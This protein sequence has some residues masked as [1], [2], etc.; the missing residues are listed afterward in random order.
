MKTTINKIIESE[1]MYEE[2]LPAQIRRKNREIGIIEEE[3][4]GILYGWV[5]DKEQPELA[6]SVRLLVDEAVI[7]QAKCDIY[8]EDLLI[9]Q[10]CSG[11]NGFAIKIPDNVDLEN[12]KLQIYVESELEIDKSLGNIIKKN[13]TKIFYYPDYSRT[14]PYQSLLNCSVQDDLE[15]ISGSI[16]KA[17]DSLISNVDFNTNYIFHLHWL[18]PIINSAINEWDAL[19]KS[20]IFIA[21]LKCFI[22]VGGVIVWTIHNT[23]S[24]ESKW[25]N[26]EIF[27]CT[28]LTKLVKII[29]LHSKK[30]IETIE[31][32]YKLPKEKIRIIPHPNFIDAYPNT[33]NQ[34]EC[35]KRLSIPENSFVFGF[36]GQIRPYK[37][38]ENLIN[39]FR[40]LYKKNKNI[41]LLIAGKVSHPYQSNHFSDITKDLL[42]CITIVENYI[43]DDEL[44]LY[45]N[46]SDVIVF[47]YKEVLT[48]GSLMNALS[49]SKAVLA[50]SV[51]MISEVI[52]D[53]V[54]GFLYDKSNPNELPSSL[55]RC[56]NHPKNELIKLS[57]A[58]HETAEKFNW[59]LFSKDYCNA[60]YAA[61]K[62][63]KIDLNTRNS[64]SL[65]YS[66]K[67]NKSNKKVAII[68][69]MHGNINDVSRLIVSIE[70][71]TYKDIEIFLVD[72]NS[73]ENYDLQEMIALSTATSI[74][75]TC[76]KLIENHGYAY[77]NN[78]AINFA[79]KGEFE[80]IWIL[81]PDMQ[82]SNY[83]LEKFID[84]SMQYPQISIFGGA[85][86]YGD[87]KQ[88]I[89]SAGGKISLSPYL[90]VSHIFGG[91]KKY[92]LPKTPYEVDYISGASIFCRSTIFNKG[93]LLPEEYF[94]YFEETDWSLSLHKNHT[95]FLIDPSIELFHYKR[96][97]NQGL[98]SKYYFYYYIRN[99]INFTRKFN[100]KT[101]SLTKEKI[102]SNFIGV[103]LN[104]IKL[105]SPEK[106]STYIKIAN[107][108]LEDGD[109]NIF[110]KFDIES[111]ILS[112]DN[113]F[114]SNKNFV[115]CLDEISSNQIKGWI[116]DLFDVDATENAVIHIDGHLIS[117]IKASD[118]REDL[119][120]AGYGAGNHSFTIPIDNQLS[121]SKVH[122][123]TLK[124][125]SGKILDTKIFYQEPQEKLLGRIDG[126]KDYYL[127]GWAYNPTYI[128]EPITIEVLDESGLVIT[129]ATCD[130]Y[131]KDLLSNGIGNGYHGF[132]ARLPLQL[133]DG[134]EHEFTIRNAADHKEVFKKTIT[135]SI[136]VP[137][138]P[139]LPLRNKLEWLFMNREARYVEGDELIKHYEYNKISLAKKYIKSNQNILITVIMPCFNREKTIARS[140]DSVLKQTYKN[141]ELII[142]DD[143]SQDSTRKIVEEVIIKTGDKRIKFIHSY[144][145]MGVSS[146]RNLGI[147]N[148]KGE[149]ISYLDSDNEWDE[150]F[151]LICINCMLKEK[152]VIAYCGQKILHS[153]N[154]TEQ[155]ASI[156]SGKF[157]LPLLENKNYIDLNCFIHTK[158]LAEKLG[159]FNERLTRLVD[160][161]FILRLTRFSNPAYVPAILSNYFVDRANNQI[162]KTENF[163]ENFEIAKSIFRTHF[164][165]IQKSNIAPPRSHQDLP[166]PIII[167]GLGIKNL[168][169]L[170]NS[171]N[172]ALSQVDG[173]IFVLIDRGV[174]IDP[175]SE[176]YDKNRVSFIE[177]DP[178]NNYLS[179]L[180]ST[181]RKSKVKSPKFIGIMSSNALLE[182]FCVQNMQIDLCENDSIGALNPQH[183]ALPKNINQKNDIP[184]CNNNMYIDINIINSINV[185]KIPNTYLFEDNYLSPLFFLMR[186]ELIDYLPT[187][188]LGIN[189]T[190]NILATLSELIQAS[191]YKI[192]KDQKSRAVD[193][194]LI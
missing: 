151:L 116:A 127:I 60:I 12:I 41:H 186:M 86:Y 80:F 88:K 17:I 163:N 126:I 187:E 120:I 146:A 37:G 34:K 44:Q 15:T 51:G 124:S 182:P 128:G 131:R 105:E 185:P 122:Q 103:W 50:P 95:K 180:I 18:T 139:Q 54:N 107:K 58:A 155:A 62:I 153:V 147:K 193:C 176:I 16:D 161:E 73:P 35:R 172:S 32:K 171:I 89:W 63:Y 96:S 174:D 158:E 74:P 43:P 92:D 4:N 56:L 75:I 45:Y 78:V 121:D 70:N 162:T 1:S 84:T 21:K 149:F 137:S 57:L 85:I 181:I 27:L 179:D 24:H 133:L 39:S 165:L 136:P 90:N 10:G 183:L 132:S 150:N 170:N 148:S 102:K 64:R 28:E 192:M 191:G 190:E 40:I 46:A 138:L 55:L 11:F 178:K 59:G 97:E 113:N 101:I 30:D 93:N 117:E 48:S 134:N 26:V 38:V 33:K 22:N 118:Y 111:F 81:N 76:L 114:Q 13:K 66:N 144:V 87:D 19:R 29:H 25:I 68:I 82:I 53:G 65:V 14:N 189:S 119:K 47:P 110:G 168:N 159:G 194:E 152:K 160:W 104:K 125:T 173:I 157:C 109:N 167:F 156:R 184:F 7:S 141:F 169:T 142:I 52:D 61:T 20:H 188:E 166:I 91:A 71:S 6:L 8:R 36:I 31:R 23:L 154:E 83:A 94:L 42:N 67:I 177:N 164:H 123:I 145:N 49:F 3:C 112:E 140:I 106:L 130:I 98:P 99:A 175:F 9:Y 79:L 69:V 77:G 72:N 100:A 143:G 115:G 2:H 135:S 108:A 5:F 129:R